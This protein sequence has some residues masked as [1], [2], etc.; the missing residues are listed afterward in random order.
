[1]YLK[2]KFIFI[3]LIIVIILALSFIVLHSNITRKTTDLKQITTALDLY[4]NTENVS[5]S[6]ESLVF[7]D[8]SPKNSSLE[9]CIS[10]TDS[11]YIYEPAA[12]GTYTL[13]YCIEN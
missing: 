1:M 11:H 12:G 10:P 13:K 3:N 7:L 8:P 9:D 5:L 2:K 4:F 6:S